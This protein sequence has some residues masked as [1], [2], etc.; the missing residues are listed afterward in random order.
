MSQSIVT[1]YQNK[2]EDENEIREDSDIKLVFVK[3]KNFK[4]CNLILDN[5]SISE[6][7]SIDKVSPCYVCMIQ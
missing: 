6:T 4:L 1:A 3:R 5:C 2:Y 7:G